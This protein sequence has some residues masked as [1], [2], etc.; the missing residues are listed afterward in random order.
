MNTK[1][2]AVLPNGFVV[3]DVEAY[4]RMQSTGRPAVCVTATDGDTIIT[5]WRYMSG[6]VI[7]TAVE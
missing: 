2:L 6:I 3:T 1:T 7:I 4:A 5:T